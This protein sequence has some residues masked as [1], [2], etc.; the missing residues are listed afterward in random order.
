[1]R[2]YSNFRWQWNTIFFSTLTNIFLMSILFIA[3]LLLVYIRCAHGLGRG[4]KNPEIGSSQEIKVL[5]INLLFEGCIFV[6]CRVCCFSNCLFES[7]FKSLFVILFESLF[8][9][10]VRKLVCLEH[11]ICSTSGSFEWTMF[12][13]DFVPIF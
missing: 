12:W 8:E 4:T 6:C 1:M 2:N 13:H 7:L 9:V 11:E 5:L 10:F 3:C